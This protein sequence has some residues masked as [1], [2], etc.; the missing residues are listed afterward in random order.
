MGMV[1]AVLVRRVVAVLAM[2]V[3]MRMVMPRM[4]LFLEEIGVDIELAVKVEA[5]QVKHLAQG[6]LAKMHRLLRRARV[7]V[8]EPVHQVGRFFSRD[9]IGLAEEY[10]VGKTDLAARFLALIELLVGVFG[11]DQ[12]QDRIQQITLGNLVVHEKRL[13]HRPRV[14]QAGGLDHHAVKVEQTLAL[15]GGEQLQRLAQV[16]ADGAS[17]CSRCSSG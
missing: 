1:V 17:K 9:Q 13:R 10:L 5:A 11:I 16:F 12:G 2:F 4:I 6:H 14:G 3:V 15:F 7:H 8:L